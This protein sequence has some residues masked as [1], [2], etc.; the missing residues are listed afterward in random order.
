[1]TPAGSAANS[2]PATASAPSGVTPRIASS[3]QCGCWRHGV[4]LLARALGRLLLRLEFRDAGLEHQ[5]RGIAFDDELVAIDMP[6]LGRTERSE[7]GVL[8]GHHRLAAHF[9]GGDDVGEVDLVVAQDHG[10]VPAVAAGVARAAQVACSDLRT[11][12]ATAPCSARRSPRSK[13]PCR[14]CPAGTRGL[15]P[16]RQRQ[17][18][19]HQ[20]T[21]TMRSHRHGLLDQVL[22]RLGHHRLGRLA[23]DRLAADLQHHRHGQRRN[24]VE[25]LMNDSAPDA[26]E[27]FAE[28]LDVEQAR[29]RHRPAPPA[30]ARGR[31]GACA[32]RR[33]RG[34]SRS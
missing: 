17:A 5:T 25:R 18:G 28:P 31:P 2:T 11:R 9:L 29:A 32:A 26:R 12:S 3:L 27:H 4:T 21:Q 7:K 13:S 33:R 23:I 24:P 34:R 20:E 15:R 8:G 30:T 1:M 6:A 19:K 22:G 10:G 16:S 14:T